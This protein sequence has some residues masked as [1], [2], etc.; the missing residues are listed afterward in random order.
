MLSSNER[1][2]DLNQGKS[3][4]LNYLL[5]DAQNI[6]LPE[7]ACLTV[8]VLIVSKGSEKL[9]DEHSGS[10]RPDVSEPPRSEHRLIHHTP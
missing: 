9:A 5:T 4:V 3:L 2:S 7:R 10:L 8:F 1:V 6:L